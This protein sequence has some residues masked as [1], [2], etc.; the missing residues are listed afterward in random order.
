MS[1]C[2]NVPRHFV[3]PGSTLVRVSNTAK[4]QEELI[5][6]FKSKK[7]AQERGGYAAKWQRASHKIHRNFLFKFYRSFLAA[8]TQILLEQYAMVQMDHA[9]TSGN[10][11]LNLHFFE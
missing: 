5:Y 3:K 4:G 6:N 7:T 2:S 11:R 1:S 10:Q 8:L 9:Y